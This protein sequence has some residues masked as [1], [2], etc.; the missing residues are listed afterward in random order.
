MTKL[1]TNIGTFHYR[2]Q[3]FFKRLLNLIWGKN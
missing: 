2:E 1:K 3:G